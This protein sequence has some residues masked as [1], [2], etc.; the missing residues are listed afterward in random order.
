MLMSSKLS[1]KAS[2]DKKLGETWKSFY[3]LK[4]NTSMVANM[5]S[6]VIGYIGYVVHT[7]GY[8]SQAW[9]Q[10]KIWSF[11]FWTSHF[12]TGIIPN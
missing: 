9:L 4:Q 10:Y 12:A 7:I 5:K 3:L 11:I 8:E 6:N 2:V 1:W